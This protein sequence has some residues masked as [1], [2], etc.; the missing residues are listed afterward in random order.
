MRSKIKAYWSNTWGS[1]IVVNLTMYDANGT[2]TTNVTNA[3]LSVYH[4][5]MKRLITGKSI[6]GIMRVSTGFSGAVTFDLPETV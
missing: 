5:Q 2:N 6:A 1:D 3:T 4:V